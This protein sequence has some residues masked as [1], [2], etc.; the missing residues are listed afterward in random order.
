MMHA[1][2]PTFFM[3]R[4][5]PSI[6][7]LS[8]LWFAP[9]TVCAQTTTTDP[10][11]T[12]D[13]TT[14]ANTVQAPLVDEISQDKAPTSW[15][16]AAFNK[17]LAMRPLI[18][19]DGLPETTVKSANLH[20]YNRDYAI[21]T[22]LDVSLP[23]VPG[24]DPDTFMTTNVSVSI[25]RVN[26]RRGH[27]IY[28]R[29]SFFEEPGNADLSGTSP[30]SSS[31]QAAKYITADRRVHTKDQNGTVDIAS[32]RGAVNIHVP[33]EVRTIQFDRADAGKD[34]QQLGL[35]AKLVEVKRLEGDEAN[36]ESVE[37]TYSGSSDTLLKVMA[38][39]AAGRPLSLAETTTSWDRSSSAPTD[40]IYAYAGHVKTIKLF[41]A[42]KFV[43]KSLPFTLRIPRG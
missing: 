3:K 16:L 35:H 4:F 32:I 12:T 5:L 1:L 41:V 7:L 37:L 22:T 25:T 2:F 24:H 19:H 27:D 43:N 30:V 34:L 23:I 10:F 33:L 21:W 39:N 11:A 42:K 8:A 14:T 31:P 15:T 20:L 26:D 29:Q 36:H 28:D 40:I 6:V 38:F 18:V 9:F 17:L 13:A